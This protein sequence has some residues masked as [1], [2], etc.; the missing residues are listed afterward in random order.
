MRPII[1]ALPALALLGSTFALA[2]QPDFSKVE[3]KTQQ[4]RGAVY[5]LEGQGGNIGVLIGADGALIVDDQFAP[6]SDKIMA[7]VKALSPEP[8]AVVVNTHWH[9]DH[10][11]GN[12]PFAAAGAMIVAHDNVRARM[13]TGL[14]RETR[15]TPAAAPE[16][17]PVATFSDTATLYWNG[18]EVAIIHTAPAHTDGDSLVLFR[19]ANVL[20][21]GDNFFRDGYPYIDLA[22]GG[23]LDGAIAALDRALLLANDETVIIPGHGPLSKKS[24]IAATAAML[25]DMRARVQKLIDR[26]LDEEA[27]VKAKPLADLDAKWGQSWIKGDDMTRTAY[28]SLAAKKTQ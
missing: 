20:H 2:Q 13:K 15:D 28:K 10:T 5:M 7:A 22:S 21:M 14:K 19:N 26:G 8:V 9:G 23:D 17:L 12:A 24:D 27:V 18:E 4:A 11:G 1:A 25:R 16:A 6:L 3:I